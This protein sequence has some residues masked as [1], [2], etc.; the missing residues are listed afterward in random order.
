MKHYPCSAQ[1]QPKYS[2]LAYPVRVLAERLAY[3]RTEYQIQAQDHPDSGTAWVTA[4]KDG[5]QLTFTTQEN[6]P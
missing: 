4:G 5:T 2:R 1:Y 3:G 6:Q